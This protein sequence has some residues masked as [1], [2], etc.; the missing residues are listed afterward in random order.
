MASCRTCA[1]V[2]MC[3]CAYVHVC[4]WGCGGVFLYTLLSQFCL[5]PKLLLKYQTQ[6][7]VMGL[8]THLQ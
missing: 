8:R 5:Q 1:C 6:H 3:I 4:V 2:Y 7:I